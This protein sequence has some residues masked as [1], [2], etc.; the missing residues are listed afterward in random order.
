MCSRAKLNGNRLERRFKTTMALYI[1]TSFWTYKILWKGTSN[2]ITQQLNGSLSNG[3]VLYLKRAT[4][5]EVLE[6]V[7]VRKNKKLGLVILADLTY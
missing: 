4:F 3:L 7:V 6:T 1:R 2:Y 5:M